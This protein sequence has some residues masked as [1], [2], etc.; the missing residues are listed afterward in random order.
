MND[1]AI[2]V[3]LAETDTHLAGI[4]ERHLEEIDGVNVTCVE[5]I[6]DACCEELSTQHHVILT[7][8]SLPDGDGIDLVN[9][10][11]AN[12]ACPVV[13]LAE[14]P[15]TEDVIEALRAGVAD[16]V[17]KPIDLSYLSVVVET[18]IET[19]RTRRHDAVRQQRLRNVTSRI[20]SERRDLRQQM[21]LICKDIVQAYR[22][23]AK[24]VSDSDTLA[25]RPE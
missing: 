16:V 14:D 4:I 19:E 3:L 5:S 2:E 6:A 15:S 7:A 11:R 17:C 18:L 23:L 24:E 13:V 9:K 20:V 12:N 1:R 21:D 22:R 25:G 10:I 8:Q